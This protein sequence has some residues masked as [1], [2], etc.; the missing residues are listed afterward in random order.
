MLAIAKMSEVSDDA[1][2][3]NAERKSMTKSPY[4]FVLA[5]GARRGLRQ[6]QLMTGTQHVRD[7]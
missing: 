5:R 2:N 4:G 7:H 3:A 1:C 6:T